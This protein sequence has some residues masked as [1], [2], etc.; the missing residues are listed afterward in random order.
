[1]QDSPIRPEV[2]LGGA[3]VGAGTVTTT[4]IGPTGLGRR[5]VSRTEAPA[6]EKIA[7]PA[8]NRRIGVQRRSYKVDVP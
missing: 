7:N 4:A 2:E 1:M 5:T 3:Q 8:P 6:A